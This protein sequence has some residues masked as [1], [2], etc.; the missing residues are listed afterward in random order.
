MDDS[1]VDPN[2][3]RR[4]RSSRPERI[5]IGSDELVRND[6]IPQELGLGTSERT[7]NRGDKDGAPYTYIG[8]VKYRPINAYRQFLASCVERRNQ[9]PRRRR[10]SPPARHR[11]RA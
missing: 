1:S 8:G 7:V 9:A 2:R 10:P 5:D 3:G 4:T 11:V 6:L